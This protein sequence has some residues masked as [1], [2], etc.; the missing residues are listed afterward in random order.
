MII[1]LNHD[2]VKQLEVIMVR[3]GYKNATHCVQIMINQVSN[4]LRRADE[5]QNYHEQ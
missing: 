2:T 3:T 5:R 4:K 1:K